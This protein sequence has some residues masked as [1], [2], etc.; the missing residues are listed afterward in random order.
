MLV[1]YSYLVLSSIP[2]RSPCRCTHRRVRSSSIAA[3]N[4]AQEVTKGSH[5]AQPAMSGRLKRRCGNGFGDRCYLC[6]VYC[7]LFIVGHFRF[8]THNYLIHA[9][10]QW[11]A[12]RLRHR[13][14]PLVVIHLITRP[15]I[16]PQSFSQTDRKIPTC[17]AS[18]RTK[19]IM[20]LPHHCEK[21]YILLFSL[22]SH[23][24]IT[25]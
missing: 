19:A 22:P 16:I 21:E 12:P 17:C 4:H 1:R 9:L 8:S 14:S 2:I 15:R 11:T 25:W 5:A 13:R 24:I 23:I 10:R 20:T 3:K 7:L 18:S 6:P